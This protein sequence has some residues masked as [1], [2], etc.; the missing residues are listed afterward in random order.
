MERF[1]KRLG[2]TLVEVLLAVAI[3]AVISALVVPM[4]ITK[5]QNETFDN[6]YER[7]IQSLEDILN[8]LPVTEKA[9]SFDQT[10]MYFTTTGSTVSAANYANTSGK[11]LSK[12]MRVAKLCN[13]TPNGCF[14]LNP[15]KS[16][17]GTAMYTGNYKEFN[18]GVATTLTFNGTINNTSLFK[19]GSC[20]IL[21]NGVSICIR[22]KTVINAGKSTEVTTEITGWL[23]LNGPNGPNV[24]DRDFR[25][26]T[27]V[28]SD[29][30]FKLFTGT[31]GSQIY[32]YCDDEDN[33]DS[34]K[35]S[36]CKDA[37]YLGGPTSTRRNLCCTYVNPEHDGCCNE[38]TDFYKG[39]A[40]CIATYANS[41]YYDRCYTVTPSQPPCIDIE[42][43]FYPGSTCCTDSAALPSGVTLN[44]LGSEVQAI[45]GCDPNTVYDEGDTCCESPYVLCQ[46]SELGA[47]SSGGGTSGGGG[48]SDVVPPNF[49]VKVEEFWTV[50]NGD[51]LKVRFTFT[52][53]A[54][55][56]VGLSGAIVTKYDSDLY[57]LN[58]ADCNRKEEMNKISWTSSTV[59]ICTGFTSNMDVAHFSNNSYAGVSSVDMLVWPGTISNPIIIKP[60]VKLVETCFKEYDFDT[61]SCRL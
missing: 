25:E 34:L 51:S 16:K 21:K 42:T 7:E 28:M 54:T 15:D 41:E 5:Y 13:N 26:F 11:F 37:D 32:N 49:T 36:P 53:S 35:C 38:E 40:C 50:S 8:Q 22:P 20:A 43:D 12:Y 39:S 29:G 47:T 58:I 6:A 59:V 56:D 19:G 30:K 2:F 33:K 17:T 60:P 27:L 4:V 14:A 31:S 52:P 48:S 1:I 24:K 9:S 10:M 46:S 23:D 18:S 57:N 55:T 44:D 45:C 61:P 3:V